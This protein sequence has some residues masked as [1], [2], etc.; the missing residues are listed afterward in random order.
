MS[1]RSFRERYAAVGARPS[2]QAAQQPARNDWPI[3][4]G[5]RVV[6]TDD[7]PCIVHDRVVSGAEIAA[8]REAARCCA[9]LR[10]GRFHDPAE[11]IFL[12]T[13][14][15]GLAGGTGTHVFLVGI[16]RFHGDAL[17]VRQYFM[18][19]PGDER[20]LLAALMMEL[21]DS[22]VLVT[23]NG[24]AFDVPLL[25]TRFRMH[26]R[27]FPR[28]DAHVDLLSPARAIWKH[29]LPS[30]SL[31]SIERS[32][33]GVARE[34]DA[35]GWMIPQL[36]FGYLRTREIETLE[37]VFEHNRHDIVSLARLTSLVHAYEAG[38]AT[39]AHDVDRL[40]VS[41]YRLRR[42]TSGDGLADLASLWS[43]PRVPGALRL[44]ALR[45]LSTALKRLDQ[46]DEALL[47]WDS[48]LRDPSRAIRLYAAEE[49]AKHYEHRERDLARALVLAQQGADGA[50]LAS[51]DLARDAFE[52]RMRRL[53]RKLD[54]RR[55]RREMAERDD[56]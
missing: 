56:I 5:A 12:D 26:R 15:T 11:L 10:D 13:E 19:H 30:C 32:V 41:L 54:M 25:E 48:A 2:E 17:H 6:D 34:L 7:G 16:G 42:S 4:R 29:R 33:L 46:L 52:R 55:T 45:E 20:A 31:G 49:L 3:P 14:T 40:A 35:P 23:Y 8:A 18:R 37:P 53:E 24:R 1:G 50:L 38:V 39:P 44:R 22:G 36:Y 27:T 51:D 21:L 28:L 47:A 9:M 43:S